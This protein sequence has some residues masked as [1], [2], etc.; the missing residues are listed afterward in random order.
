LRR[1]TPNIPTLKIN[2]D[3]GTTFDYLYLILTD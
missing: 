2:L 3:L 1:L